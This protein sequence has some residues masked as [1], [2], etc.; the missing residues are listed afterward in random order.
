MIYLDHAATSPLRPEAIEAMKEALP[1]YGNPSS[2]HEIG[3][4]AGRLLESCRETIA[5]LMDLEPEEILFTSGGTEAD[6]TALQ[7]VLPTGK[8]EIV[9]TPIEHHAVLRTCEQLAHRG[10]R[11]T[12][13]PVGSDGLV[14]VSDVPFSAKTGLVSVMAA[15][16]ELGTVQPIGTIAAECHRR[17]VLFH[18][19]AVSAVG[20]IPIRFHALGADYLS[21]SAHKFGGPKGIGALFCK[22]DAPLAPLLF[23]GGQERGRRAGTESPLLVAGMT[24]AL[25]AAVRHMEKETA[26]KADLKKLLAKGLR[27]L[28]AVVLC[29]GSDQLAGHLSVCFPGHDAQAILHALDLFGICVSAGA[30]CNAASDEPSHVLTAIG[31]SA[32]QAASC[33]RFSL[34]AENTEEEIREVLSRLQMILESKTKR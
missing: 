32:G 21:L 31:L 27:N 23:G 18:T 19:D 8:A 30:A 6:A 11:T 10:I 1:V 20:Q 4:R 13:L 34:G 15:N 22:K 25:Q 9:T 24:A 26:R 7:S 5:V 17:G 16:N 29:D 2:A 14:K 28:G 33:L 12:F 3:M